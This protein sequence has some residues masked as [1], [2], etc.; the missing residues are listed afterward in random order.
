[1]VQSWEREYSF[2]EST[3]KRVCILRLGVVL[4]KDGGVF[5]LLKRILNLGVGVVI[6]SRYNFAFIHIEDLCHIFDFIIA[7]V[8]MEGVV[9]VASPETIEIRDFYRLL[10]SRR[11][12][13]VRIRL[14][15][16]LL[17]CLMGESVILVWEGQKVIPGRLIGSG[18][19]FSYSDP[20]RAVASLF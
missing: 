10:C 4:G 8:S 6:N 9:N 17:R 14:G 5:P 11:R 19:V 18:F 1:V 3:E 7:N 13:F 12:T 2:L 15:K 20:E 16:W